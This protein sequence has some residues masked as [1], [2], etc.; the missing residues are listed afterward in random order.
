MKKTFFKKSIVLLLAVSMIFSVAGC[1]KQEA[2]KEKQRMTEEDKNSIY[3]YETIE[4]MR[5]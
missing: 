5:K 2:V 1:G 3:T 4:W